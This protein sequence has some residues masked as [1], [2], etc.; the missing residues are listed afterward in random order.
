VT[1]V[2]SHM[3]PL[4][5]IS[6]LPEWL[7]DALCRISTGM[8][9]AKRMLFTDQDEIL[10]SAEKP[11][12]LT[13]VV[14]VVTRPDLGDRTITIVPPPIE[15]A[16]RREESDVL[17]KFKEKHGVI[18][19]GLFDA[20]SHGLRTLPDVVVDKLPRM[21]DFARWVMACEG[22][23]D[24]T[25]AFMKAYT[26]NRGNAIDALLETDMVASVITKLD[27]PW[28]GPIGGLLAHLTDIAGE[29][30]VKSRQWPKT[31]RGLSAAVRRLMPFMRERGILIEPP[32]KNDKTRTW[33]I[34]AVDP[35]PP[36]QP[37][38]Q[39][40]DKSSELNGIGCSGGL[41]DRFPDNGG[42]PTFNGTGNAF[43]DTSP[44][45]MAGEQPERPRPPE[46]NNLA[47][48]FK[49][50][51]LGDCQGDCANNSPNA[52][53]QPKIPARV[54]IREIRHPAI[55]AGPDD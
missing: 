28:I 11:V 24:R 20:V 53:Q 46:P 10:I 8:A 13:S 33:S 19:S 5:N 50:L 37:H 25:G 27:L 36:Q 4:D 41:G 34:R 44:P 51:N 14:E 12:A 29:Q 21:A 15:E 6:S 39:P 42:D 38:Q 7:S 32:R 45:I 47:Y 35:Q 18:L 31:A 26:E 55:S 1:V 30:Q 52:G 16:K 23:Y 48:G 49:G 9:Y 3:I 22:A 17:R 40:D 2:R 43:A 54:S